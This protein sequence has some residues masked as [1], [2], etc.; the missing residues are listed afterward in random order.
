MVGREPGRHITHPSPDLWLPCST[1]Q[2]PSLGGACFH[3]LYRRR[4][5]RGNVAQAGQLAFKGFRPGT[6]RLGEGALLGSFAP[7]LDDPHPPRVAY[8][9]R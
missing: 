6:L 3:A 2:P 4:Q 5:C 1:H 8:R 7:G 9:F